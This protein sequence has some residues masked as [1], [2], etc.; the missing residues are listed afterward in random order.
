MS[1]IFELPAILSFLNISIGGL[2]LYLIGYTALHILSS[3]AKHDVLSIPIGA[4]TGTI[5]SVHAD[6]KRAG[7][8]ALIIYAITSTFCVWIL[9][10]HA[11]PYQGA[12][13][14]EASSLFTHSLD[15]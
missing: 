13:P 1:Y 15:G 3:H 14:L 12:D 7:I 11:N 9:A 4:F 6:R 10:I 5:A 8:K 2:V